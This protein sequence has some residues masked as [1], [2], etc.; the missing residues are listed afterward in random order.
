MACNQ[1]QS[2]L[3]LSVLVSVNQSLDC[4]STG[5][6]CSYS[7][8]LY[9]LAGMEIIVTMNW[10][11]IISVLAG[12]ACSE[13]AE[14]EQEYDIGR[15]KKNTSAH[16]TNNSF[17]T[18]FVNYNF[19][20][21][22]WDYDISIDFANYS[23][24]LDFAKMDNCTAS[25]VMN[26][27]CFVEMQTVHHSLFLAGTC[28][29][30]IACLA[31]FLVYIIIRNRIF[32]KGTQLDKDE[33]KHWI[34][35]NFILSF[36][37]RDFAIM[38]VLFHSVT[39]TALYLSKVG[40]YCYIFAIIANFY[41]M[42]AEGLWLHLGV[43]LPNKYKQFN[44]MKVKVCLVSW[45]L[46]GL[47]IAVWAT[48]ETYRFH[49]ECESPSD[50]FWELP[51]ILCILIPIY[52]LLFLNLIMMIKV[53]YHFGYMLR[54]E[55][56]NKRRLA[57]ATLVLSFLLGMNFA[58]PFI[59]LPSLPE[60]KL[61]TFEITRLMNDAVSSL[62]GFFVAIF[63]VLRNEEVLQYF[64]THI[65]AELPGLSPR[66]SRTS[67]S[68]QSGAGPVREGNAYNCRSGSIPE[69][70]LRTSRKSRSSCSSA[71]AVFSSAPTN[72]R[73]NSGEY[74]SNLSKREPEYV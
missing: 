5:H 67:R 66:V 20:T 74:T 61:C 44:F 2:N 59:I 48:A 25:N 50:V 26:N 33:T 35:C 56:R 68:S 72:P 31:A 27:T 53:L 28:I 34:H 71:N 51:A 13:V 7:Y 41:W 45:L 58:I 1:Y 64:K 21:D 4:A 10:L 15:A 32:R 39:N 40:F 30:M 69:C 12:A 14:R 8:V 23:S 22:F 3:K 49:R 65:R 57:R 19:S 29:S 60:K 17:F 43:F 46:P 55:E 63:Y 73:N 54:G 52:L 9:I 16:F 47:L 36:I 24:S 62:Q 37:I 18:D 70:P 6:D 42:F 38:Y 11:M